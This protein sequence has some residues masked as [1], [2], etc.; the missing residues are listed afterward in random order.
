MRA[1]SEGSGISS[2]SGIAVSSYHGLEIEHAQPIR[3]D[4]G[5]SPAIHGFSFMVAVAFSLNYIMGTGFLTLPWAFSQTG[6]ALSVGILALIIIPSVVAVLMVLE[7]M[8]RAD[9]LFR[10]FPKYN[11]T[12][13]SPISPEVLDDDAADYSELSLVDKQALRPHLV[14]S[15]KF[16]I[17]EVF[18]NVDIRSSAVDANMTNALFN[19]LCLFCV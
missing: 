19:C 11:V 15:K 10:C 2:G 17:V 14:R 5:V 12:E 4:R 6:Y 9:V 13:Y 8:A 16:E 18:D 7:A 3:E 1:G